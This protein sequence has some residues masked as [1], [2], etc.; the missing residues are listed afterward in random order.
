M[1]NLLIFGL[2]I[3]LASCSKNRIDKQASFLQ[4]KEKQSCDFGIKSFTL[5]KREPINTGKDGLS[6]KRPP[7]GGGAPPPPPPPPPA[8]TAVL[9]LDFDGQL[10]SGTSWN[11]AS[12]FTCAPA[13]LTADQI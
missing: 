4:E 10:V 6:N 5:T 13:N 9:L 11:Y 1:K 8:G 2:V 12:D 3:L 7:G